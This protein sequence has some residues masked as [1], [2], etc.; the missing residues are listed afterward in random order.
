MVTERKLYLPY[1][2]N[3]L[4][5]SDLKEVPLDQ[6]LVSRI[7]DLLTPELLLH[8]YEF[9]TPRIITPEKYPDFEVLLKDREDVRMLRLLPIK[10]PEEYQWYHAQKPEELLER[11]KQNIGRERLALS[12][13]AFPYQLPGD[14]RQY[15]LW[16]NDEEMKQSE[17]VDFCARAM[18]VLDVSVND[19]VMFERSQKATAKILRGTFKQMRHIH[20][21]MRDRS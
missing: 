8:H 5:E 3:T 10:S 17:L 7:P 12:P 1:I 13:N 14:L 20:F 18:T 9:P 16:I 2:P 11:V 4:R 6:E 19:L 21:W 15:L